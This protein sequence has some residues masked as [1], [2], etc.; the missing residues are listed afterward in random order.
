MHEVYHAPKGHWENIY[1]NNHLTGIGKPPNQYM[2]PSKRQA[3]TF[4]RQQIPPRLLLSMASRPDPCFRL[5]EVVSVHRMVA[6]AAVTARSTT[7][8]AL[9]LMRA[10]QLYCTEL[11]IVR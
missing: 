3:L 1:A 7:N 4:W 9:I 8:M 11:W 5:V 2:P 6:W 10:R